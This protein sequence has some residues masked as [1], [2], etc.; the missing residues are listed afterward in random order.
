MEEKNKTIGKLVGSVP[1]TVKE[2]M[3]SYATVVQ[4]SCSA[5]LAPAKLQAAIKKDST[6]YQN[7]LKLYPKLIE[8]SWM[9]GGQLILLSLDP[10]YR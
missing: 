5:S 2:E 1:S 3:K 6:E 8:I 4:K 10:L 7:R 9:Q